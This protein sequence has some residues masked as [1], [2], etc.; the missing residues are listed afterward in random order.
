MAYTVTVYIAYPGTPLKQGGTSDFGHMWYQ[1]NDGNGN[2]KSYGFAPD[3]NNHGQNAA[4]GQVYHD[5]ND[6]YLNTGTPIHARTIEIT[7]A[8][9]NAM[10]FF[11]DEPTKSGFINLT[12]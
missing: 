3:E 7:E 5:D 9:Y 2:Q 10:K 6:T 4:P 8:Q 11:G 1:L 12:S